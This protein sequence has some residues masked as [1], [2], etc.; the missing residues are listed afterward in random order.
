MKSSLD[1][2]PEQRE[3]W[4]KTIDKI[5]QRIK[6]A[7]IKT[8]RAAFRFDEV[9]E[10]MELMELLDEY[11]FIAP[12]KYTILETS[13]MPGEFIT[14]EYERRQKMTDLN[15]E[16]VSQNLNAELDKLHERRNNIWKKKVD[17]QREVA[18][19]EAGERYLDELILAI[20]HS[21]GLILDIA[22]GRT[23][24]K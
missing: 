6:D 12:Q 2:T 21:K 10:L 3:K 4:Q 14:I 1:F 16:N 11:R 13:D 8:V 19:L 5:N 20:Q 9:M 22:F 7:G 17:L 18:Q 15:Y 24:N 23:E